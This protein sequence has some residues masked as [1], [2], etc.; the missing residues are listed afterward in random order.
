MQPL[1]SQ[2]QMARSA[3]SDV[4]YSAIDVGRRLLAS[5]TR[6]RAHNGSGFVSICGAGYRKLQASSLCCQIS[7]ATRLPLQSI[8]YQLSTIQ[9]RS[10]V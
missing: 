7:Q 4:Q 1:I 6:M 3:I 10:T 9:E 8:N 2:I 5:T